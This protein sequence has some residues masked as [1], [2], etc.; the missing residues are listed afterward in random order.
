MIDKKIHYLSELPETD[1]PFISLYLSVNAHELFEQR[2]KDRIFIKN[3]L[4]KFE[5]MFQE[6]GDKESLNSFRKDADKILDFLENRLISKAHGVA[7]FACDKLGV[8]EIFYSIMP[9]ENNFAVN[10]IPHLKQLAYHVDECENALVIMTDKHR[11]RIFNVKIGGFILNETDMLHNI[12]R[13]HK[14]GGWAQM[15][16]QRHI[17]NQALI[18]YKEV[19]KT[20]TEILDN[21]MYDNLIL[22][23]QHHEMKNLE[24]L[25]PKRIKTKIIDINSLDMRED[26]NHILEKV[27]TD[28]QKNESKKEIKQIEEI[29]EKAPVKSVTGMQDTIKL[30]E[31]DRADLLIIPDY[32]TYQ[33]WKCNGCLYVA[34]DQYQA[35]CSHYNNCL[36]ETDLIEEAVRLAFRSNSKIELVKDKAAEKLEKYE[37]IGA[38]IRY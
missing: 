2:E 21:N 8:F 17:E 4:Q 25:L 3:S 36:K 12:H 19:A 16:Y 22:I 32:K 7:I 28:L 9:F 23:G 38:L 1:F 6:E 31:E 15:R 20:A 29:I 24:N 11:S 13:F 27:I 26:I 35:G 34:K 14:Q 33:G 10:S 5:N 30:I 18:H 37:G